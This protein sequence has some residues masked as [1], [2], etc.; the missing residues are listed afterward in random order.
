MADTGRIHMVLESFQS[1]A[2][3][4][5]N[6]S[7]TDHV[8]HDII[9]QDEIVADDYDVWGLSRYDYEVETPRKN[10]INEN[11]EDFNSEH[12]NRK[13][14]DTQEA[15]YEFYNRYALLNGFRTCKYNEHKIMATGAIFRGQFVY[16]KQGFKKLDDK[17]LN[18]NKKG[19][20]DLRTGCEAMMHVTLSKKLGMWIVDKFQD[21]HNHPLTTIPS[22]VIK[23][24]SHSKYHRSNVCKS[25]VADLN[26]EGL[27]P[28]QI[29]KVV[30][31]IKPSEEA[32]MIEVV[33]NDRLGKK[34]KVKCNEDD[35]IGDLKKLVAA[36]TGTRADKIR[37]QK[38][39][40]TYKDHITLKDYEIHDGMG[41]EL[42][43]N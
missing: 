39:Y 33:L 22:K 6:V 36:Q 28:S 24:R 1:I 4:D 16:N 10:K 43:Y 31:A 41:L 29:T 40:N 35:T 42:Y 38:W 37:I 23:Y 17:R 21:V 12:M 32:D 14:F 11:F 18:G 13:T 8:I 20:R 26:I 30:N 27:K 7:L 34:V 3:V 2:Q 19:R 15:A 5:Q 9:V 25:L